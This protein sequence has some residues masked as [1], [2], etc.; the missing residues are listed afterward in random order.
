MLI[1]DFIKSF[2]EEF[3]DKIEFKATD[4]KT[5]KVYKSRGYDIEEKNIRQRRGI[6]SKSLW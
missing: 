5:N 3:G 2:K 6:N 4:L 1:K